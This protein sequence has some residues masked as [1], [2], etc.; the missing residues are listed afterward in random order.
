MPRLSKEWV[1]AKVLT[2]S[3]KYLCLIS[4][5]AWEPTEEFVI[6]ARGPWNMKIDDTIEHS[7]QP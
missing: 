1:P 3:V 5:F 2:L 7:Y 6:V 4:N